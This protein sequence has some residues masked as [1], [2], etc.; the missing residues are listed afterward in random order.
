[1]MCEMLGFE[2]SAQ[3]KALRIPIAPDRAQRF[4]AG[5]QQQVDALAQ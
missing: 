5:I 1:M 2:D 4:I 3:P